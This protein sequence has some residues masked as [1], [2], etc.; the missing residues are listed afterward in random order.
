[1]D[2][3]SGA[4]HKFKKKRLSSNNLLLHIFYYLYLIEGSGDECKYIVYYLP[5]R[6]FEHPLP[7]GRSGDEIVISTNA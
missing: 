6:S 4:R 5:Q 3:Q 1:M 7:R 2:M